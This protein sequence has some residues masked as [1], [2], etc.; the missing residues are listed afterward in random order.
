MKITERI[1][2]QYGSLKH[3]SKVAGINVNSL[4]VVLAGGGKSSHCVNA[5]IE[6][7]IIKSTSE[8]PKFK[9][10]SNTKK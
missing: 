1:K 8:L 6:H 3:F 2:D 4:S 7:G 5:L 9:S 10:K